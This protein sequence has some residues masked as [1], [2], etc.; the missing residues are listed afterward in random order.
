MLIFGFWINIILPVLKSF[1]CFVTESRSF[2]SFIVSMSLFHNSHCRCLDWLLLTPISKEFTNYHADWYKCWAVAGNEVGRWVDA[3]WC[4]G[5]DNNASQ[6]VQLIA[7]EDT[8]SAGDCRQHDGSQCTAAGWSAGFKHRRHSWRSGYVPSYCDETELSALA[9]F[10][11]VILW[12]T[13]ASATPSNIQVRNVSELW[14]WIA[15]QRAVNLVV[16]WK[17]LYLLL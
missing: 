14:M 8:N 11:L 16:L 17:Q 4:I 7:A 6:R 3:R 2:E 13:I 1:L 5:R 9:V 10:M 15:V 12:M